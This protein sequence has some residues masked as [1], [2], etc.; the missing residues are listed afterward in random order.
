MALT[1]YFGSSWK[2]CSRKVRSTPVFLAKGTE[3]R[4]MTSTLSFPQVIAERL[5]CTPESPA[6]HKD[7]LKRSSGNEGLKEAPPDPGAIPSHPQLLNMAARL[8]EQAEGRVRGRH[9]CFIMVLKYSSNVGGLHSSPSHCI[10]LL[11]ILPGLVFRKPS[12][13]KPD[14]CFRSQRMECLV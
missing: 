8:L 5:F 2:V 14:S 4:K 13:G 9:P 12:P 7:K 1:I 10:P 11:Y 6:L 3:N